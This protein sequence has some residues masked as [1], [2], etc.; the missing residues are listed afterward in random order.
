M[1]VVISAFVLECSH[2]RGFEA[3]DVDPYVTRETLQDMGVEVYGVDTFLSN[4]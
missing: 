3:P 2:Y 4:H 1:S